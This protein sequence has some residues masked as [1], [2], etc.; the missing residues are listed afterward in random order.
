MAYDP[1]PDVRELDINRV[2]KVLDRMKQALPND[3]EYQR[4]LADFRNVANGILHGADAC[5]L[6]TVFSETVGLSSIMDSIFQD[7]DAKYLQRHREV[8]AQHEP[9]S[10]DPS[11]DPWHTIRFGLHTVTALL[12]EQVELK[13]GT[14]CG[15]RLMSDLEFQRH[16]QLRGNKRPP[17]DG[18]DPHPPP[19]KRP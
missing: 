11:V 12:E 14:E 1:F 9:L 13:F 15:C 5:A 7:V 3:A 19:E 16:R 17:R 2:E 8:E 18:Y 10:N 4:K 6:G